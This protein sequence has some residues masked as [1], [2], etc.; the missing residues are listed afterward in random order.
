[1]VTTATKPTKGK[2]LG[3]RIIPAWSGTSYLFTFSINKD[4][5]RIGEPP[6]SGR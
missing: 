2:L 3:P 5:M 4:S 6:W 1:V